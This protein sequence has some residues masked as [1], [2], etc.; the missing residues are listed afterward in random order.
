MTDT[1]VMQKYP[2]IVAWGKMMGSFR[3]YIIN[4]CWKANDENAPV[5]SCY[6]SSTDNKWSCL[7]KMREELQKE[8]EEYKNGIR[9]G[10]LHD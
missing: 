1:Q 6:F 4:Q 7:S 8:L 10:L 3:Y 2:Y 5:D 9:G